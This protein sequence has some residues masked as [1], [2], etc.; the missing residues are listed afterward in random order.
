M[1]HG[2]RIIHLDQLVIRPGSAWARL[3]LIAGAVGLLGTAASMLLA[4]GS[5]E[6]AKQ[7]YH[8]WLVAVVFFLC[9]GPGVVCSSC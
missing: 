8:S 6:S 7:F 4:R 3:P 9:I 5:E 1:S 2:P